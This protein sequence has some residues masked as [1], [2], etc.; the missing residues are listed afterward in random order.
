MI[1]FLGVGSAFNEFSDI[2]D[3]ALLSGIGGGVCYLMIAKEKINV[4]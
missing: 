3:A 1:G 4:V 2:G